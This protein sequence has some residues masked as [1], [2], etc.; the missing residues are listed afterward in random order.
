M[1][2]MHSAIYAGS[3]RHRR[4][5]ARANSFTYRLAQPLVDLDELP[6]LSRLWRGFSVDKRNVL[7]FFRKDYFAPDEPDL[8]AA[9]ASRVAAELGEPVTGRVQLLTHP[10]YFGYSFNPVSFYFC[11]RADG[12]PLAILAEITNTPWDERHSY[13]LP[14]RADGTAAISFQLLGN[15]IGRFEFDKQFHVSPFI[16]MQRRYDWRFRW[17]GDHLAVH[18]RV[19]SG[20]ELEF[21]ATLNLR[22]QAMTAPALRRLLWAYPFATAQVVAKIYYQAFKLW[23]SGVPFIPHPKHLATP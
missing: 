17:P 10:R 20:N 12:S 11:T 16:A 9:V 2:A 23:L 14:W 5:T 15:D 21:D 4:Y 13:V 8:R 6:A 7:A 19:F 18:M 1:Q 22:R 3:V